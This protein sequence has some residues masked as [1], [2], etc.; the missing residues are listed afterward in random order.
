[1]ALAWMLQSM[2]V[3]VPLMS[4]RLYTS[5]PPKHTVKCST[6][7][8]KDCSASFTAL[9]PAEVQIKGKFFSFTSPHVLPQKCTSEIKTLWL[10]VR[11]FPQHDQRVPYFCRI[12]YKLQSRRQRV[13]GKTTPSN[14][15]LRQFIVLL[16]SDWNSHLPSIWVP[17]YCSGKVKQ[18][19]TTWDLSASSN[20]FWR[21][22]NAFIRNNWKHG[23]TSH[24]AP[25]GLLHRSLKKTEGFGRDTLKSENRESSF[26]DSKCVFYR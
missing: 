4:V 25:E 15:L 6:R 23:F 16:Y 13:G 1:M 14:M 2:D 7:L 26:P 17:N 24:T 20:F 8:K 5:A 9:T 3:Q 21:A 10:P 18:V 19:L 11:K 12:S 22:L